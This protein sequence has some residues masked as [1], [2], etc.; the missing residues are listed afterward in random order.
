MFIDSH[1]HIDGTEFDADRAEVIQ[2][3]RDVGVTTI[4]NIGT[5]E[6]HAGVFER[7]VELAGKHADLYVALGV[8]PHDA[9]LFDNEAEQ[10][11]TKLITES[12]RV[13][14]WGEIGLDFHYDN[15]PRDIQVQVF[16]RQ[17]QLA[18]ELQLPVIIHTRDSKPRL[19][20][21]RRLSLLAPRA[22]RSVYT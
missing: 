11:I 5:G 9:R 19:P 6:P 21:S 3:A 2:R 4:L 22:S 16:R 15:S 7:A 18:R 14:A 8:H 12:D 17:L 13:I 20:Q 10:L 1:A